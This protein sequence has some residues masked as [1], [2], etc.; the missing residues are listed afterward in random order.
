MKLK[1]DWFRATLIVGGGLCLVYLLIKL[2]ESP[3]ALLIS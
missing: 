3:V 2:G 1:I